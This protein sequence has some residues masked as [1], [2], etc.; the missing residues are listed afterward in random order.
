VK[1]KHR[2]PNPSKLALTFDAAARMST[3]DLYLELIDIEQM[4]G[5][6]VLNWCAATVMM[7]H[8]RPQHSIPYVHVDYS[9]GGDIRGKVQ[10]QIAIDLM[11]WCNDAILSQHFAD[12]IESHRVILAEYTH[13]Q[14]HQ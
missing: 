1:T 2:T 11:T 7:G 3:D 5:T 10:T 8:S 6:A 14:G 4:V 12:L 9:A 13:R